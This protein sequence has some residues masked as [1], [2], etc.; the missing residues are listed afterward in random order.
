MSKFSDFAPRSPVEADDAIAQNWA[1]LHAALA[2][3]REVEARYARARARLQAFLGVAH[4]REHWLAQLEAQCRK[5]REPIVLRVADI[6]Q[7]MT[8]GSFLHTVH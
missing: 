4:I 2:V 1:S 8:F 5:E 7:R 6:H 3:L